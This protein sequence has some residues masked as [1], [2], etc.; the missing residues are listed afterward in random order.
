M[1]NVKGRNVRI[2]IAATY[3]AAKT[4]TAVTLAN[5]G[6]ATSATHGLANDT[7]GYFS[8][9]GG[10]A[11]LEGQACRVKNQATNTFE[12]QGLNTTNFT[13]FTAGTFTP[14]ATW[15]TLAESTSYDIGGGAAPRLQRVV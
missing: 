15:S 8:A 10:M 14:V 6:V 5:P 12:L 2:E 3:A 7:V 13:A 4:V 1:A 9:V 11:Q